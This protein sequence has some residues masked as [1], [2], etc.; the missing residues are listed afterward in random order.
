MLLQIFEMPL[1]SAPTDSTIEQGNSDIIIKL[2]EAPQA[3]QKNVDMVVI[4]GDEMT[5]ESVCY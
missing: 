5:I 3:A 4:S 1:P 2:P